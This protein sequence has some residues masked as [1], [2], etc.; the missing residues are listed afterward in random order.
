M[1]LCVLNQEG[2][3]LLHRKMQAGPDPFLKAIAPYREDLVVCVE[4]LFTWYWLADLCAQEGLPVVLGH[5]LSMKAIHG[6]KAKHEKI[7]AHKIAVLRRGGMLPQ[8]YVYPAERRATGIGSGGACLSRAH[9]PSCWPI[10]TTPI[11]SKTYPRSARSWRTRRTGT[12]WRNAFP[13]LP[14]RRASPGTSR[15][16]ATTTAC[17]RPGVGSRPDRQGP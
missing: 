14:S 10:S 11:A 15:G 8:A 3:V 9:G 13:I 7:D 12:A 4:C 2:E 6:G 5:A 17:S 1:S 16:L